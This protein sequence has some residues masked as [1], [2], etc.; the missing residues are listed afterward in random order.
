LVNLVSAISGSALTRLDLGRAAIHVER[1]LLGENVGV[2]DQ[3][4][5]AFGG[6]N[7]FDFVDGRIRITPVLSLVFGTRVFGGARARVTVALLL[8][9]G[10]SPNSGDGCEG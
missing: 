6:I 7:R 9:I 8:S 5:A 4:H 1:N 2:Q 3:L 10:S